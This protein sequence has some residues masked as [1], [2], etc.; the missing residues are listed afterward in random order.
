MSYYQTVKMWR[1]ELLADQRF[2]VRYYD[3]M[4]DKTSPEAKD[5]AK[6]LDLRTR[7][8]ALT[9]AALAEQEVSA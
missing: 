1:D 9:D 3:G 2:G 5:Q 4:A 7:I 6:L 8:I